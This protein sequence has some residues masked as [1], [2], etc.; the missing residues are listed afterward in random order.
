M[1]DSQSAKMA[2]YEKKKK[3]ILKK[4]EISILA[5]WPSHIFF[6]MMIGSYGRLKSMS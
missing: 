2:N 5:L 1:C 3:K 6:R 4:V